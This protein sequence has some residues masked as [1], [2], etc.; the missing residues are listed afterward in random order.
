MVLYSPAGG[1]RYRMTQ[2]DRFAQHVAYVQQ[3]DLES[4]VNLARGDDKTFSQDP[5]VGPWAPV[6][7]MDEVFAEV[8]AQRDSAEYAVLVAETA[9]TLFDRDTVPGAEPEQLLA[10][11][12]PALVVPGHDTSHATSAARYLEE[13]LSGSDYWDVPPEGQTEE[14]APPRIVEFLQQ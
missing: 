7:R 14:T 4:V 2:H 11:E 13:C 3:H 1:P 12:I 10:L 6:I 8:Y 9:R 5:R